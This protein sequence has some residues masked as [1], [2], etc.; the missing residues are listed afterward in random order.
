MSTSRLL[1]MGYFLPVDIADETGVSRTTVLRIEAELGLK[2][3]RNKS[4]FRRYNS[5][6][7]EL[8]MREIERRRRQIPSNRRKPRPE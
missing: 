6:E 3:E 7:A 8:I 2:A 1:H 5:M 4:G